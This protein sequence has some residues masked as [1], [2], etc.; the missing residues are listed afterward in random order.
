MLVV[1]TS[2][3]ERYFVRHAGDRGIRAARTKALIAG[4]MTSRDP[5]D[6]ARLQAQACLVAAYEAQ[7][8]PRRRPSPVAVIEYLM[9]QHGLTRADMVPILGT[10]SRVSEVLSGKKGL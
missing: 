2:V 3:A 7:R 6:R 8:W 4:L 5:A 1:G 9:D 10:A